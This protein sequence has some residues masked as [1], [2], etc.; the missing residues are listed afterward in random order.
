MKNIKVIFKNGAVT[1]VP[2][3]Y[4]FYKELDEFI[5]KDHKAVHPY[6]TIQTKDVSAIVYEV[7]EDTKAVA[8]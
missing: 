2:Y 4:R 1:N 7:I 3:S 6:A 8:N 5:G